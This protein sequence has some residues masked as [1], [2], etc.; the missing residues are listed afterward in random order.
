MGLIKQWK[1]ANL[2]PTGFQQENKREKQGK[3]RVLEKFPNVQASPS[4]SSQYVTAHLQNR[5]STNSDGERCPN[6]GSK[7]NVDKEMSVHP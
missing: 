5:H 4:G 7:P 2:Q 1:A 6:H 3:L